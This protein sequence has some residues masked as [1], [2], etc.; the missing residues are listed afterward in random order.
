MT[1]R[2]PKLISLRAQ[3]LLFVL[4][5]LMLGSACTGKRPVKVVY[6]NRPFEMSTQDKQALTIAMEE[7]ANWDAGAQVIDH[8]V[9]RHSRGY[10]VSLLVAAT[11]D[12]QGQPQYDK[13]PIRNVEISRDGEVTGYHISR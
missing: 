10:T 5:A 13:T 4:A 1:K 11:F 6:L 3:M 12:E 7:V 9:Q 8:R 2:L